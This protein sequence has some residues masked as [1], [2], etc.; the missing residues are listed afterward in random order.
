VVHQQLVLRWALWQGNG[1][2][3]GV[4]VLE[5]DTPDNQYDVEGRRGEEESMTKGQG[6]VVVA[7][8]GCT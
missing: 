6:T 2:D 7:R 1:I 3:A 4:L 5:G 8:E